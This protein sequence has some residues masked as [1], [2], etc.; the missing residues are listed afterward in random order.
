MNVPFRLPDADLERRFLAEAE[1]AGLVNLK[2]HRSLGGLRASLYNALPARRRRAPG[3]VHGRL[4]EALRAGRLPVL[5]A[6]GRWFL[7]V[8]E[9]SGSFAQYFSAVLL[10]CPRRPFE[11][12][13]FVKQVE[14]VGVRSWPVV[15][16]T[17]LFTGMVFTLQIYDGFKRFQAEGYVPGVLGVALLRELVPVL[18]GMMVAGRVG[19]AMAAELGTM[20]VTNQ[21]DALEVNGQPTRSSSWSCR[22][23]WRPC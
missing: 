17:A 14:R 8:T 10:A 16:V 13:E 9:I 2:G 1:P 20:R 19:S 23:S 21:I 11:W 6:M 12:R 3:R 5:N 15:S 7:N 22:V 4:R 18:G